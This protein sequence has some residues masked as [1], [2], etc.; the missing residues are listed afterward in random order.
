MR[1]NSGEDADSS[2]RYSTPSAVDTLVSD[3]FRSI[4]FSVKARIHHQAT[5]YLSYLQGP[6][7]C[8]SI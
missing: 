1:D 7:R 2:H 5:G 3:K 6:H 4:L 8:E